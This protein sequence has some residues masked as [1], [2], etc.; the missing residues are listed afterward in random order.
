MNL[1]NLIDNNNT[2]KKY[3]IGLVVATKDNKILLLEEDLKRINKV[4]YNIPT[5]DIE[6]L[7]D[8]NIIIEFNKKYDLK[9]NKIYGYVNK[10]KIL[11]DKC[12]IVEQINFY[13]KVDKDKH[14][15]KRGILRSLNSIEENEFIPEKIK[16]TLE[17]FKY[18]KEKL[19]IN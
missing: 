3:R 4:I 12:D 2:L 5:I 11:D 13:T 10:V 17:I 19:A 9:I 15:Y 7:D 16:N 18:N 1:Y 8:D 14:D 6:N